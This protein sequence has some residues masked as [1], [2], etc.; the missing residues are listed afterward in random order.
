MLSKNISEYPFKLKG[1]REATLV[2]IPNRDLKGL[3]K[4]S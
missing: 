3:G 4:N 2:V 1:E